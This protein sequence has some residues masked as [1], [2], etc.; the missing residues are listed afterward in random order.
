ME[1]TIGPDMCVACG[2]G[3]VN[4]RVGAIIIKDGKALMVKCQFA[5]YCYSV[6]G[7]IKFGETAEQAVVREVFEET[8]CTLSVDRLGYVSEVYFINDNPKAFGKPVYELALYF[9]MTVP[10]GFELK[11]DHIGDGVECFQWV[12]AD[13]SE[14]LYPN[15]I[16]EA[17]ASPKPYVIFDTRDD[18]ALRE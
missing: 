7:R 17:I 15:F 8:G 10:A 16:R 1:N 6:G 2:D 3:L 12:S 13:A 5:D 18:R 4:V 9:Y 11:T 14:T